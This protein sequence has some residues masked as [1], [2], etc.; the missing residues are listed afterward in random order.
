MATAVVFLHE[1]LTLLKVA[2]AAAGV[3]GVALTRAGGR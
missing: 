1:P 3:A 2:G